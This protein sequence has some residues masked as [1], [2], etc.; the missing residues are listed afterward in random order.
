MRLFQKLGI[1][2]Q[3]CTSNQD[4]VE[5]FGTVIKTVWYW[6]HIGQ[7]DSIENLNINLYIYGQLI[8]FKTDKQ[9]LLHKSCLSHA[10][11]KLI[12]T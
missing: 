9:I 4:C 1:A 6:H 5:L 10:N 3:N 8:F 7:W 11:F 12:F 2:G